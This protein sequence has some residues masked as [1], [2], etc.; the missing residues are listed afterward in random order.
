MGEYLSRD[1][2]ADRVGHERNSVSR[3]VLRVEPEGLYAYPMVV[4]VGD[5]H[6]DAVNESRSGVEE[7]VGEVDAD[8]VFSGGA[9]SEH[10]PGD[11]EAGDE[12]AVEGKRTR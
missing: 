1:V 3:T 5:R 9:P 12:G 2:V 6:D 10:L 7:A 11:A 4:P 8:P